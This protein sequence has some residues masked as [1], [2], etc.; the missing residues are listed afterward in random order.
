MKEYAFKSN[1]KTS[2]KFVIN[3]YGKLLL[4]IMTFLLVFTLC[5]FNPELSEYVKCVLNN[6][7]D[8]K[9]LEKHKQGIINATKDVYKN[10]ESC[11]IW[12]E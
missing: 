10:I 2:D 7:Y 1:S 9:T 6:S 11:I 12:E 5:K 3:F 8:V 4:C